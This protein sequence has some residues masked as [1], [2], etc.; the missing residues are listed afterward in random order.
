MLS[1]SGNLVQIPK[2]VSSRARFQGPRFAHMQ[3]TKLLHVQPD[4]MSKPK[5]TQSHWLK[6]CIVRQVPSGSMDP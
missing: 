4:H 6:K 1:G 3:V 2:P 5:Y